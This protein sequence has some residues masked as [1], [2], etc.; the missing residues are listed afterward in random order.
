M[1]IKLPKF[2]F[3]IMLSLMASANVLADITSTQMIEANLTSIDSDSVFKNVSGS[4]SLGYD[5]D[6]YESQATSKDQGISL[7]LELSLKRNDFKFGIISSVSKELIKEEQAQ[8][9]DTSLF[10]STPLD[11]FSKESSFSSSLS[12]SLG[13]P[14]S[15]ASRYDK[16]MYANFSIGPAFSWN[17][18]KFNLAVIPRLG[19][20]F[21]KYK[22]TFRGEANTS[23]Y[24]KLALAPSYQISN[25]ISTQFITSVTQSWTDNHTRKAPTYASVISTELKL[26]TT[27]A[28]SFSVSNEDRIYKSD[29]TSSNVKIFDK[30]LSVYSIALTK[31]F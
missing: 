25:S 1:L 14:T 13:L 9:G 16:E 12:T 24:T 26:D 11:L 2:I 7:G 18:D 20:I 15:E 4:V 22:T 21:N 29:G 6:F 27:L 8:F 30:T 3:P 19:K 28:V 10:F 31:D 23:Y 5:S 17:N